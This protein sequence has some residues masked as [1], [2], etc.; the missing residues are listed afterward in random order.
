MSEMKEY[1]KE[2]LA[3]FDGKNG[4]KALI[5]ANG[6]V[7]EV[8]GNDMWDNGEH[9]SMHSAGQD[10]TEGLSESPHD[11]SIFEKIKLVGTLKQ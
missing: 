7:Y 11:D 10:L 6:K 2:E 1:T 8:T 4:T 5:A 9:M 3:K